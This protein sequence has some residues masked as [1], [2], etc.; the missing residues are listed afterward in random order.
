MDL[1]GSEL[2]VLEPI[3]EAFPGTMSLKFKIDT[4]PSI[5]AL[6]AKRSAT[7]SAPRFS[8]YSLGDDDNH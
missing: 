6:V 3:A 7:V 5:D 2:R 8:M 4:M 1:G